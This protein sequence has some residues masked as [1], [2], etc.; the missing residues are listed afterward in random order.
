MPRSLK[1]LV[2]VLAVAL[3]APALAE[4]A[5]GAVAG[6]LNATPAKFRA[7][8]VVFLANVPGTFRPGKPVTI[9]Q[10]GMKF[11]PRVVAVVKG[12][13]VRFQNS[14]SVRHNVFSPDGEKYDLGTWPQGEAKTY[15][16]SKTGTYRQLCNV[17][18]EMQGFV[19]VLDNPYFAVVGD[20]GK[21]EIANV[22]P[23][24][25]E[26]KTWNEALKPASQQVTVAAGGK[27]AVTVD[28]KR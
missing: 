23:G 1:A 13:T 5:G 11:T 17:H 22:P 4:D 15:T 25:Y 19:I 6:T 3:A 14:D 27:A 21:F 28:I 10:K 2:A 24:T 18:P 7:G 16:F 26:L 9:D 12:T 8:T 20:D